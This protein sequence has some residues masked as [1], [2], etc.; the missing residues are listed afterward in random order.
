MVINVQNKTKC[1]AASPNPYN[2]TQPMEET[3]KCKVCGK[4]YEASEG[5]CPRCGCLPG[6]SISAYLRCK[7]CGETFTSSHQF[8]PGC[9]SPVSPRTADAVL[10]SQVPKTRVVRSEVIARETAAVRQADERAKPTPPRTPQSRKKLRR[11]WALA[12]VVALLLLVGETFL[13]KAVYANIT[14]RESL[15]L[16]NCGGSVEA[17]QRTPDPVRV[18]PSTDL[19][20][21][22]L[23]REDAAREERIRMT[24]LGDSLVGDTASHR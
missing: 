18:T 21:D 1:G 14:Y 12:I 11:R 6:H 24:A 13:V 20:I 5:S 4:E 10:L 7:H 2:S 16:W 15:K 23:A 19:I 9:K 22:S 3:I 17:N 8:C